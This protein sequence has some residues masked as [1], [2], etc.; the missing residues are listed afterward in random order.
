MI[1]INVLQKAEAAD[2][3]AQLAQRENLTDM[4]NAER[5]I[6]QHGTDVRYNYKWGKWLVWDGARW[7]IDD[8]GAIMAKAKKT[9]RSIYEEAAQTEDDNTRKAI[10]KHARQSEAASRIRGMIELAQSEVPILPEE[11][12]KSKWLLNVE[13]GTIDLKT[14]KLKPH[15]REDM[16]TKI[17]PVTYDVNAKCPRWLQFLDE[18][19]G[20]NKALVD[21][22][23]KA[24]GLSLTGDTTEHVLLIL[25]GVGRNGKSTFLNTM[26]SILGDYAIEA[27]PN[28]LLTGKNDRHPTE[29]ADLFGKRMVIATETGEGRRLAE[30]LVKQLTGGDKIKARRMREDFWEFW[31]THKLWLATNHKPVIKGTDLAIWSRLKLVPFSISFAGREDKQLP[32]KLQNERAGILAWAVEGCLKWQREGLTI[33]AEVET[34]TATYRSEQDIIASFISDVCE[35]NP[36]LKTPVFELYRAY[37]IWCNNN[38]ERPITQRALTAA[39]IERG[40]S[41]RRA[42]HG[43]VWSWDGLALKEEYQPRHVSAEMWQ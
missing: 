4:G 26:L 29:L 14:G 23:Q 27:A 6:K 16:L 31:P 1:D 38:G 42:G 37:V 33:P 24:A 41:K 8:K 34:A 7:A 19:M 35:I 15:T 22:L 20:G 36:I 10:A 21:F 11:L 28:L 2:M 3:A 43:G 13:N 12:D 25:Y 40:Y 17:A 39:L 32:E 18:V 5:F 30:D 9:V